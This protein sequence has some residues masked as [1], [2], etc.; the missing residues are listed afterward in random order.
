MTDTVTV[1][2]LE[3]RPSD[4]PHGRMTWPK[5]ECPQDVRVFTKDEWLGGRTWGHS[6]NLPE[7]VFVDWDVIPDGVEKPP[8]G[9][10][11]TRV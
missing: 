1:T 2:L 9:M 8:V 7:L 10:L 6:A 4:A 3:T 5:D 11:I